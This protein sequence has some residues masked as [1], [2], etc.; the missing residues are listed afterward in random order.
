[1][2]RPLVML[3]ITSMM[4]EWPFVPLRIA[5]VRRTSPE[6]AEL[7]ALR[8]RRDDLTRLVPDE[9]NR[10]EHPTIKAVLQD[11]K[12]HVWAM[13]KEI[14]VLDTRIAELVAPE[15]EFRLRSDLCNPT[16]GS[17]PRRRPLAWPMCRNSTP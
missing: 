15:P 10:P 11:F 17:D 13:T 5:P 1:M 6:I 8:H 16:K 12:R 3:R 2:V 7:R 4:K 14:Q 9:Q